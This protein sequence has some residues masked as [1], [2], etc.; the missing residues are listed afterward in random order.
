MDKKPISKEEICHLVE[1]FAQ[2][3]G[4]GDVATMKQ[5]AYQFKLLMN[6]SDD[7]SGSDASCVSPSQDPYPRKSLCSTSA[8]YFNEEA[9]VEFQPKERKPRKSRK[10]VCVLPKIVLSSSE[11]ENDD[12]DRDEDED[13]GSD[14]SEVEIASQKTKRRKIIE[15]S[16][17]TESED[18]NDDN[19]SNSDDNEDGYDKV[20]KQIN[21]VKSS[22]DDDD[23][24]DLEMLSQSFRGQTLTDDRK[25]QPK[26]KRENRKQF[27]AGLNSG[28][29]S[30]SESEDS[31]GSLKDFIVSDNED[32]EGNSDDNEGNS[33]D[34]E[35]NS[36]EENDRDEGDDD[37]L[38]VFDNGD[39]DDFYEPQ[40]FKTPFKTPSTSNA[41]K[42]LQEKNFQKFLTPHSQSKRLL[43][44]F[45]TPKSVPGTPAYKRDFNKKRDTVIGELFRLFNKT[46]F[47]EQ[48]PADMQ[49]TW[50]KRMTK[51]AGFCYYSKSFN[52]RKCRIELSDKVID[53][54]ERVRDTLIHE[55][56]HAAAWMINGVQAGHGPCWKSWA[57]K[58]NIA[59]PELP[60]ISRC[61][62][63]EI[64]TKYNYV[65]NGC[66]TKFG[67]HSKSIDATKHRC[68]KCGGIPELVKDK[69]VGATPKTP[70]AYA[71]FVKE[72][73]GTV[74]KSNP[75]KPHREIMMI[76][77]E[78]F[79]ESKK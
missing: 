40:G 33:N 1:E 69:S 73:F 74:K 37:G 29:E 59:H 3:L 60:I 67:R 28:L 30:D 22:G 77:A 61:H 25:K 6:F 5:T 47:G 21:Y 68:G 78:K 45:A 7:D 71:Q 53:S 41:R 42:I 24:D 12:E 27:I 58:A 75:G 18:N 63:Y 23:D 10:S 2:S 36:D 56:C 55:L 65:C 31:E 15:S 43:S 57:K 79:R 72:N 76:I 20:K 34:N 11:D 8:V 51:T 26:E 17:E 49:I 66:G 48:L 19:V 54:V 62:Q 52:T 13:K 39:N 50:N 16:D 14:D 64:A 44:E 4:F 9:D 35:G 38:L 46:V 70:N 32:N